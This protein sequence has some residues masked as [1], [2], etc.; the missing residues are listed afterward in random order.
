M[1]QFR[2]LQSVQSVA[3][4]QEVTNSIGVLKNIILNF[5]NASEYLYVYKKSHVQTDRL[6][7][8]GGMINNLPCPQIRSRVTYTRMHA[9]EMWSVPMKRYN[10]IVY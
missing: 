9:P 2:S 7:H 1:L 5:N 10:Y 6:I 3:R 4:M 8:H